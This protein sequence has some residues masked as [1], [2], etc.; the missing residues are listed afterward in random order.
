MEFL[1]AF[2]SQRLTP[3]VR[4]GWKKKGGLELC[5]ELEKACQC[6]II[7]QESRL[8]RHTL[9]LSCFGSI[10]YSRIGKKAQIRLDL[11]NDQL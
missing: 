1:E 5:R 3:G 11:E 7:P 4:G 8:K 9:L 2:F 6:S 10:F